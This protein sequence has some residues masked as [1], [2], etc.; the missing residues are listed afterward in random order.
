[1]NAFPNDAAANNEH[2][3]NDNQRRL[4]RASSHTSDHALGGASFKGA[5]NDPGDRGRQG[6]TSPHMSAQA[7]AGASNGLREIEPDDR[8]TLTT[9]QVAE[10]FDEIG[11][12]RPESTVRRYFR[13]GKIKAQE[14]EGQFGK[15]WLANEIDVYRFARH[16]RDLELGRRASRGTL[17]TDE[18]QKSS[19]RER[20]KEA[21]PSTKAD[22]VET[23]PIETTD[24]VVKNTTHEDE[25]VITTDLEVRIENAS[26]KAENTA[27]KERLTDRS[28]EVGFL[29]G[30][31]KEANKAAER[32][33]REAEQFKFLLAKQNDQFGP[34]IESASRRGDPGTTE[35]PSPTQPLFE[36]ADIEEDGNAVT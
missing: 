7:R 1:M 16:L 17:E 30:Q 20:P 18:T 9:R 12:P 4:A 29:R 25:L 34:L 27:L 35:G 22:T 23:Q 21:S 14:I 6:Q 26:L 15:E 10:K 33:S 13:Q 24:A 3:E 31:V 2:L 8:Y 36:D 19:I 5:T 28:E 11:V 32:A